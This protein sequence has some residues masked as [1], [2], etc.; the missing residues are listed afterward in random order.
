MRTG[1]WSYIQGLKSSERYLRPFQDLCFFLQ[2]Q[3]RCLREDAEKKR[4]LWDYFLFV[5]GCLRCHNFL[6]NLE[7]TVVKLNLKKMIVKTKI[8]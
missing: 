2:K 5:G 7:N 8:S 4:M 3:V 1:W 6:S